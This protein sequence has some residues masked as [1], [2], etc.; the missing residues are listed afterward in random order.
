M[1]SK[2]RASV[3]AIRAAVLI[4]YGDNLLYFTKACDMAKKACHLDRKTSQWFYIHSLALTAQRHF[5]N[6]HDKSIPANDEIKAIHQAILL[7]NRKNPLFVYHKLVIDRDS[8][9]GNFYKNKNKI[10]DKSIFQKYLQGNRNTAD[11]V[12][13]VKL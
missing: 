12:K 3:H 9:V 2:S 6:S 10:K 5:S 1:D 11:M 13:Y 7:S 4:E 8:A